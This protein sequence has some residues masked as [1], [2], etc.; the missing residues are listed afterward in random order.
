MSEQ[1]K[2]YAFGVWITTRKAQLQAE[3]NALS[4]DHKSP[5]ARLR[6]KAG[7]LEAT[8]HIL[9]AYTEL[10]RGDLAKFRS[11]YLGGQPEEDKE[12]DDQDTR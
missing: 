1:D 5:P 8:T 3:L 7:H 9:E 6:I 10:Y 12:S 11:E 4:I 2:L